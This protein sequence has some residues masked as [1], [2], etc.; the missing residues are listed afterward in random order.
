MNAHPKLIPAEQ[1]AE[2]NAEILQVCKDVC[3]RQGGMTQIDDRY[4][5]VDTTK[6]TVSQ[7]EI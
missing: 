6:F 5:V 4:V 7:K 1:R 3:E 2:R